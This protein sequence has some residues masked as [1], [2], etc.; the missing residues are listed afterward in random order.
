MTSPADTRSDTSA[1]N[2]GGFAGSGELVSLINAFDWSATSLGCISQWPQ[3]VRSTVALLLRSP[4]PIVTLWGDEGIMIYN[5]AYSVFAGGRH[6]QLLGSKVRE[7]WPEVADF[8]DH[9]VRTVLKG[10]VLSFTDRELTLHRTGQPEQVW[11]NLDYSPVV[12]DQGTPIGVISIVLETTAKIR[13]ERWLSGERDRL[14]AMFEQAPGFMA[15][16]QGPD[17]VFELANPAYMQLVGHRQVLG[18][19]L[20]QAL[21]E[22]EGQ[23]FIEILDSIYSSGEPFTGSSLEVELQRQPNGPK[24]KRLVDL[25]YQ[26]VKGETGE[27]VGI[28]AQGADVTDRRVAEEA[29]RRSEA[30]FRTFAQVMPNHVWAANADGE[31]YWFNDQV[32]EY[33]GATPGDLDGN[34]WGRIVHPDD[35]ERAAAQWETSIASREQYETE[36]RIRRHDGAFRWHIVRALPLLREDGSVENWI[37]T[38]TDIEEQRAAAEALSRLNTSLETEVE[39][40]T[41]DRDRMWRLS[42]DIMLVADFSARIVSVNPA[43]TQLLGWSSQELIGHSFMDL[44]HPDDRAATLNEVG[45]LSGGA[46]TFRFENRYRKKDG[47]YLVLS[48]SAVPSDENIHAV[49]RDV[50]A[51]R[52]SAE[53]LR[54]TELALQQAQKME[55]IG[56]LT[57]GVAHD[58]NN[59]LQVVS[60]NLQLLAKDVAGNERAEKR[61][62]NALAGVSRG[63]KLASQLLAFGR[64]QPL[65][66]KVVNVGR[67]IYGM[68][69]MLRRT[70]GEEIEVEAI[71]SGGLWNTLVDP[72]QIENAVLNLAINARDAME[73]AGKLTLEIG[74]AFLDSAYA[75]QHPDVSPGQ[76][77]MLAVSDTGSGMPPEIMEK[78][79]EPFFSTKPEGKGTGLG[80]SM[81]YGFVKQS[82]GHVKIYSEVGHGTTVKIYL[83]RSMETEDI[84]AD[85]DAGPVTG[86][87]E[88]V[89]VV[90]DDEGVRNTVVELLTE[91]GY[92]VLKARDADSALSVIESGV[93]IDL[94]FT[95]VV[96]PGTLKSPEMARKARERLPRLAVL[97]TSG[98][99]ENSIVH[100]GRLDAGV[101]LLSKPYTREALARKVR[102]VL[103]NQAQRNQ[104]GA[105]AAPRSGNIVSR[106]KLRILLVEDD[107]LIRMNTAEML[108]GLGHE[109]TEADRAETALE[110]LARERFDLLVTD[111]GLPGL[112]GA[113]LATRARA[114]DRSILVIVASGNDMGSDPL[115][116]G[117]ISVGKPYGEDQLEAAI[118]KALT[119]KSE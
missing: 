73:G 110:T 57:G 22:I 2:G 117:T 108:A 109:V 69:D 86:G 116:E 26:P 85:V 42:T 91:L 78:V 115:P 37:G 56:K 59:L 54:M 45:R 35:L 9:V 71:V 98:Y 52:E 79:F 23:G 15:L 16:L 94:L 87:T 36:F 18:K 7:G 4:L 8:N 28:F 72:T 81:V 96:M 105:S 3:P 55:S 13:A 20:R 118:E 89:L 119:R 10:E 14:R 65:E 12:D 5:D 1:P 84:V 100:G 74:N 25:V 104:A 60:G 106:P 24:E 41:A 113:E 53:T 67:F 92:R 17:H 102:H 58:F 90:E 66:P 33:S 39:Q 21:P 101:D 62:A 82:G 31:L 111:L 95:D 75:Y 107:I 68:E 83:P 19:P 47:G 76:Y 40:R 70:L 38:N 61:I 103:G 114:A 93:P 99:T 27:I 88:T 30:Q 51:E 64:R 49:G 44:V 50:T 46:T 11:M 48:W 32:Y 97:F 80:L 6:P 29:L 34:R 77:V 43:W 112:S 63:S